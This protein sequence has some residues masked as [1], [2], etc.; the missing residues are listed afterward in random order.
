MDHPTSTGPRGLGRRCAPFEPARVKERPG[1]QPLHDQ[2]RRLLEALA[3]NRAWFPEAREA[4][5]QMDTYT[6]LFRKVVA[7]VQAGRWGESWRHFPP[8]VLKARI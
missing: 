8:I 4:H 3:G 6:L 1:G 7:E 2:D 5:V